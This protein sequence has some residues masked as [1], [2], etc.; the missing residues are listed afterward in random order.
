MAQTRMPAAGPLAPF[1]DG[2]DR[3]F[4]DG[5][6]AGELRIPRCGHCA[7]WAWP[8]QWR[9]PHCGKWELDWRPVAAAGLIY[10]WTRTWHAFAP[11]MKAVTPFV[12]VLVELPHAGGARLLGTLVGPEEGLRIGARATGDIQPASAVT[13]D[14][15]VMRWR[16]SP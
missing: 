14:L 13:S 4:W 6:A 9:C 3:P 8:P 2:L 1:E 11:Q 10:S 5:L 7:A 12:T 16:I 15:P